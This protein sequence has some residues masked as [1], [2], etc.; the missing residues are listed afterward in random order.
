MGEAGFVVIEPGLVVQGFPCGPG[1][2]VRDRGAL[3]DELPPASQRG[4]L[5]SAAAA[6]AGRARAGLG[7]AVRGGHQRLSASANGSKIFIE[8]TFASGS[9][10]PLRSAPRS[11]SSWAG[12]TSPSSC[13]A[14]AAAFAP[15]AAQAYRPSLLS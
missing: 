7:T 10:P 14:G 4:Q 15:A 1:Q 2:Q 8:M 11:G 6:A 9:A 12:S 3:G 5:P 13:R